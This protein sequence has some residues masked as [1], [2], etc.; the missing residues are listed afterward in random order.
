M[1]S[2]KL[3]MCLIIGIYTLNISSFNINFFEQRT[4]LY[5]VNA[6]NNQNGDIYFEFWGEDNAM[7]YYIGKNYCTEENINIYGNEIYSIDANNNWNYHESIIIN[8]NDDVNILSMNSQNFDYINLKYIS[9]SSKA[10]TSLIGS[11]SGD[12]S[13]RSCI[14]KLQ[15]GNYL[16][17]IILHGTLSH[18]IY[19]TIFNITSNNINNFE[20]IEKID[21]KR[22]G[23]MNSTSCFQ[24]ESTYIQCSFSNVL[25]SEYF[26]VGIYDLNLDEKETVHF[27]Y[28][29]DY[30]F[31]KIFY[32]KGEIGA[33]IFFDKDD[34]FVPKLFIR[35]L[36]DAKNDLVDLFSSVEYIVL[37]NDGKYT[38]NYG[39]FSSDAIKINDKEFVVILTISNSFDLLICLCEFNNDYTGIRIRYYYLDLSTIDIKITVNLRAF[40]FKNNFGLIFYDS[41]SE[42]PGYIFFNYPSIISENKV[43]CKTIKINILEDSSSSSFYFPEH[44]KLTNNIY[45]G[46]IKIKIIDFSSPNSSGVILKSSNSELSS[47]NIINYEDQLIFEPSITGA[48]PGEYFLEFS[49]YIEEIESSTELYGEYQDDD[50]ESIVSFSNSIFNLN[51]VVK[52]HEKC[53]SCKKLG[54]DTNYFCVKCINSFSYNINDGETCNDICNNYIYIDENGIIYCIENCN[55]GKFI[56]IKNEDE[57]YCLTSCEYN[58]NNLYKDENE[59]ICYNDCSEA[60]NRH[61]YLYVDQCKDHCP[62]NY[63]HNENNVCIFGG[64]NNTNGITFSIISDNFQSTTFTKNEKSQIQVAETNKINECYINVD[65]LIDDYMKNRKILEIKELEQCSIIYYCYSTN[66]NMD[67]LISINPNLIYIDFNKCKNSL[68]N[69]KIIE[70]NSQLLIIGKQ[71]LMKDLEYEIYRTNGTKIEDISICENSKL[72]MSSP[73]NNEEEIQIAISLYDQGYDIFNLTSSFYYDYCLS[74]Y[75]NDSDLTLSIRQNDI[76]PMNKSVCYDG[77]FYNGV[78]LT[79]KRISCLCDF[80]YY[81]KNVSTKEE[82]IEEVEE[83]FFSYILDMINYKIIICHKLLLNFKNYYNNYGFYT[84]IGILVIILIFFL[85]YICFGKN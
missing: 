44:I 35:E 10:T 78:N 32:I 43:D 70:E 61:I 16:S 6:Q 37:N 54:D 67:S 7:R 50:F 31:T 23:Y 82:Q 48:I 64:V 46:Q 21:G 28:L 30:T 8:Y 13:Y 51:Y 24:T 63:T 66:T 59:N 76:I 18:K 26:T 80:D 79:T 17:S 19:I 22:V 75:I 3:I 65:S 4:K 5:Y 57:K 27:G 41:T 73:I 71:K 72:E 84:G 52:C 36:N 55:E 39:L 29:K 81:E 62:E 25:P 33:Y 77:C 56:Y 53:S 11:H 2:I 49:I 47:G 38:L 83:N 74:A 15:N 14:I 40:I 42:Y 68:I 20:K 69:E 45:N 12:P 85:D 34:Y 1:P 60:A 58:N 9:V